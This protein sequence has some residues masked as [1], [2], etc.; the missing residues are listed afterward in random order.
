M[1][2]RPFVESTTEPA[3]TVIRTTVVK[4]EAVRALPIALAG[5][6]LIVA[7]AG[8]GVALARIAPVRQQLHIGH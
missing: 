6:A 1:S 2:P 4:E 5:A 7:I 8:T 3:P